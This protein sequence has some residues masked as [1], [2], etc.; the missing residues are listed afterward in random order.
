MRSVNPYLNFNGTTEEAFAFYRSIF[1]GEY[2]G[3]MRYKEMPDAERIPEGER[4]KI[5]HISLPIGK[6]NLMGSDVLGSM[7]QK[8]EQGNGMYIM[9]VP[10]SEEEAHR[11]FDQLSYGGGMVEMELQKMFWGDLYGSLVDKFGVRWM[12]DHDYKRQE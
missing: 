4:E 9:L 1:G 3:I 7:G 10:D 8:V 12:I 2:S 11:L 5:A 6:F